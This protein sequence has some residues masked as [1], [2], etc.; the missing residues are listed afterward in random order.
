MDLGHTAIANNYISEENFSHDEPVYPLRAYVCDSC[1]LVQVPPPVGR[2]D[3]FTPDYAYCSSISSSW[4]EHCA[5]YSEIMIPRFRLDRNSLVIDVGSND[6]YML[7]NFRKKDIPCLGIEPT[8]STANIAKEKGLETWIEFFDENLV[9]RIEAENKFAD[10]IIGNN[11]IA[12]VP[13]IGSFVRGLKRVLKPEG[14]ITLEFPHLVEVVN[15]V[16]FDTIYHEHFSYFSF[17]SLKNIFAAYGLEVFDVEKLST[18][19]GSL[20]VFIKHQGNTA[21]AV[22][23]NVGSLV[24]HEKSLNIDKISY[25]GGFT[26]K[27]LRVKNDFL[28]FVTLAKKNNKKIVGFGA[29]AKGNTFFNYCGI[30][31]D[32]IDYV[33]DE[34][35]NKQYK[36][37]PQSRIPIVPFDK[38]MLDK[39]DIIIIIPWNFKD[40]I[41]RKL[42]FTREWQAQLVTYIP[43]LKIY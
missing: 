22:T 12:H 23:K 18:H 38:L 43:D 40:E 13:D 20:R 26:E 33:V 39:P 17:Y 1:F 36:F 28:E 31:S 10:L 9:D 15:R 41:L 3:I 35:K 25:Y 8:K 42:K 7:Q 11:V 32:C 21:H 14:I 27:V 6:G 30:R 37:L 19:G 2:E 29:A 16:A 4:L 34:T 5:N 24:E